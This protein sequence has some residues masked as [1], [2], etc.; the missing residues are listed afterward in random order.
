MAKIKICKEE[1]CKNSQTTGGYCRLHYLKHWKILQLEKKK[2]AAKNL[3]RYVESILKKHPDKYI[4]VIKKDLRSKKFDEIV[5]K[6]FGGD[7][8]ES[9]SLF[10]PRSYDEDIEKFLNDLKIEKDF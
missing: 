3:N 7:L 10:E 5:D 2:K 9:E 6:Q 8:E 4:E 1:D